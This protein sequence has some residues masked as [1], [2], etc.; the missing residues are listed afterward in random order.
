M[1]IRRIL[2]PIDFS[3]GS[4]RALDYA[5][6]LGRGLGVELLLLYVFEPFDFAGYSESFLPPPQLTQ[7]IGEHHAKARERLNR[8]AAE[9]AARGP[10]T[11]AMLLDG[12]PAQ[13]IVE[14][15]R[16]E[17]IDLVVMGTLGR[18]GMPHLLLGS[19]A[20]KVVRLAPCP[21]LTVRSAAPPGP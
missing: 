2:V 21:V 7:V 11:R 20:E 10:R 1:P 14:V 5:C 15:V 12:F 16:A 6:E 17:G 4:L 3:S 19:V 13:K 9:T 8:L 18:T